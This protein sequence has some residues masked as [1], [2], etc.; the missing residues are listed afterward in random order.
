MIIDCLFELELPL[1]DLLGE[2]KL[3]NHLLAG[4][5]DSLPAFSPPLLAVGG[6]EE[7][8]RWPVWQAKKT[9]D[10]G[11][12]SKAPALLEPEWWRWFR[13]CWGKMTCKQ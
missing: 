1:L 6:A 2:N 5:P 12:T 13:C 4:E 7:G 10:V 3:E 11:G 9:L 8:M